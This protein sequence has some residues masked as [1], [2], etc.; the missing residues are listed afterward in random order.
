MYNSD[1]PIS[2][3]SEDALGRASYARNLARTITKYGI[4][5]SLCIGLLG[6]WGCGKTSILNMMIEEIEEIDRE[7]NSLLVIRFEPWNFTSTDQLL[8]QFFMVLA[9]ELMSGEDKKKNT[10]G[11]AIAEY[12]DTFD[13]LGSIPLLGS[14]LASLAKAGAKLASDKLNTGTS[15]KG[16][17]EQKKVVERLLRDFDKKLLI[18]IDDIDRLNNEQIR[19]IFQLV[20]AVARFPNTI[21]LLVFDRGV[22]V[23]A[24]EKVQEGNGN[25]YL[26]KVIQVPLSIPEISRE[27]REQVLFARL[28]EIVSAYDMRLETSHWQRVFLACVRPYIANL[29]EVNRLTNLLQFKLASISQEVNFAD[30]V[31]LTILEIILPEV[32]EWIKHNKSV[33]TGMWEYGSTTYG[34]DAKEQTIYQASREELKE[35]LAKGGVKHSTD[36]NINR[37]CG[38]I[39]TL[40]PY[41]SQKSVQQYALD[42]LRSE[43]R[44]AHPDKFDRYFNLDI[45]E[46][47]L[48]RGDIETALNIL[49]MIELGAFMKELDVRGKL[50]EFLSEMEA[51]RS[52]I[53]SDR[54]KV[55]IQT[56]LQYGDQFVSRSSRYMFGIS[57]SDIAKE[58]VRSIM[59][60]H[61]QENWGEYLGE[62]IEDADWDMLKGISHILHVMI[63]AYGRYFSETPRH[64]YERVLSKAEVEALEIAYVNKLK[65]NIDKYDILS[66][67]DS[68]IPFLLLQ[69]IDKEYADQFLANALKDPVNVIKYLAVSVTKW[70]GSAITY[71]LSNKYLEHTDD[72]VVRFAIE[73]CVE[74]ERL[75]K[76]TEY[77][78]ASAAAYYLLKVKSAE[79]E[80]RERAMEGDVKALLASWIKA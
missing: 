38:C 79:S 65:E 20:T 41:W 3:Q 72:D 45:N 24:L 40:F 13:A 17:Q 73:T 26:E 62:L 15:R 77:E 1:F 67:P 58:L 6:P 2:T 28:D 7:A 53:S 57:V 30:V 76:L 35:L 46:I 5:D 34:W 4:V 59:A 12:G 60:A 50:D 74:N 32:Y 55:L 49:S 75:L 69:C 33:L 10:I 51:H 11:E 22:V 66:Y 9:N 48:R 37:L 78:Q 54:A 27:K 71:E 36:E 80:R 52:Q 14:A 56:L 44:V 47:V 61:N 43:N 63:L 23:R 25:A 68:R 70:T 19:Q 16:I 39:K 42:E 18:V 21:Y 8:N 64:E 29:R 31:A